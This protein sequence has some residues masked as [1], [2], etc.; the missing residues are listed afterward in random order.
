MK[1]LIDY[2][3]PKLAGIILSIGLLGAEVSCLPVYAKTENEQIRDV[4]LD[5]TDEL[6][7]NFN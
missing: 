2:K 1:N 3:L 4:I 5:I 6:E 7:S